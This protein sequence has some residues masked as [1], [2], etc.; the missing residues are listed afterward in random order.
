MS[1]STLRHL[2]EPFYS[3]RQAEGGMGLGV[4]LAKRVIEQIG[5]SV[6]YE[7]K[8]RD[9]DVGTGRYS[10]PSTHDDAGV[11]RDT[12]NTRAGELTRCQ[13]SCW[14]TTTTHCVNN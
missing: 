13:E 6:V 8:L 9:G 12:W 4:F 3:T 7:S 5:G 11:I 1:D 14:S 10:P 2:G